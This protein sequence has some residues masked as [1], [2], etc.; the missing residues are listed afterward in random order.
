[1][2]NL[3]KHN[4]TSQKLGQNAANEETRKKLLDNDS[5][6]LNPYLPNVLNFCYGPKVGSQ[7]TPV[8]NNLIRNF[9]FTSRK[10][11]RKYMEIIK[12]SSQ[13]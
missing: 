13:F 10:S 5:I 7:M 1:M 2:R 4:V 9:N 6:D 3:N 11:I 8:K 12:L